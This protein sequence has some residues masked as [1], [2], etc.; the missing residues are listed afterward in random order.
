MKIKFALYQIV[1][2]FCSAWLAFSGCTRVLEIEPLS[3]PMIAL[4]GWLVED[5]EI[6]FEVSNTTSSFSPEGKIRFLSEAT[7]NIWEDGVSLGQL[8]PGA[9][10]QGDPDHRFELPG[11]FPAPGHTYRVEA[12]AAGFEPVYAET[13]VPK[14]VNISAIRFIGRRFLDSGIGD[15]LHSRQMC[16]NTLEIDIEDE[17][18]VENFYELPRTMVRSIEDGR[19]RGIIRGRVNVLDPGL[20][21][22]SG[23][24]SDRTF[25]DGIGTIRFEI[26]SHYW[27]N[28]VTFRVALSNAPI[29]YVE[30]QRQIA[31]AQSSQTPFTEPY[32]SYS[33]VAGG[34]GTVFSFFSSVD[35]IVVIP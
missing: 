12:S 2:L 6:S 33:N 34:V 32:E 7:V 1:L 4:Y 14:L 15:S 18:G 21:D 5:R 8:E 31:P 25:A 29:E 24:I 10:N 9:L 22:S 23:L 3:E 30:Y 27:L 17:V 11:V 13:Y 35:S 19:P 16:V 20:L 26:E 28:D